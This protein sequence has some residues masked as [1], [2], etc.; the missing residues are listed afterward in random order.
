MFWEFLSFLTVCIRKLMF[1]P[2]LSRPK[3]EKRNCAVRIIDCTLCTIILYLLLLIN[4][5]TFHL[6]LL[7]ERFKDL[8]AGTCKSLLVHVYKIYIYTFSF[9]DNIVDIY[10]L[11]RSCVLTGKENIYI[12]KLF[13]P[14]GSLA[15]FSL[16]TFLSLAK[17]FPTGGKIVLNNSSD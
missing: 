8:V 5:S 13:L 9:V 17:P 1:W 6:L 11:P 2:E 4:K 10:R 12:C 14:L 16:K 15:L 3:W 7:L